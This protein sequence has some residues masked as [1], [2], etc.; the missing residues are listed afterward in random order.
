V[1]TPIALAL[2]V[3]AGTWLGIEIDKLSLTRLI[4]SRQPQTP[5]VTIAPWLERDRKGVM[6]QVHF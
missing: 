3:P 6:V 5:G 1:C 2:F 4:Y